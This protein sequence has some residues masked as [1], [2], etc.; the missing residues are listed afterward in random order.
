MGQFAMSS[1][2]HQRILAPCAI[3]TCSRKERT[4]KLTHYPKLNPKAKNPGVV[5]NF[6]SLRHLS[7][8][9]YFCGELSSTGQI[10]RKDAENAE[11]AQRYVLKLG[12][13]QIRGRCLTTLTRD[14]YHNLFEIV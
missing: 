11:G 7:V 4:F 9:G 8:L 10:H 2:S 1:H 13:C 6:N 14:I 5:P 12:H 3:V